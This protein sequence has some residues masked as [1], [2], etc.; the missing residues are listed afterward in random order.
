MKAKNGKAKLYLLF[1]DIFKIIG[2]IIDTGF[3]KQSEFFNIH[4]IPHRMSLNDWK[5][6]ISWPTDRKLSPI[7]LLIKT[8]ETKI[9]VAG[10]PLSKCFMSYVAITYY[11]EVLCERL[12]GKGKKLSSYIPPRICR[13]HFYRLLL[14]NICILA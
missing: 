14:M 8:S 9:C 2:D 1:S 3:G 13:C 5:I 12:L 6:R 7:I 10:Q 11:I 4:L